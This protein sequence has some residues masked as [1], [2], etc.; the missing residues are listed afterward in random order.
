MVTI[1]PSF[2][3]FL[4]AHSRKFKTRQESLFLIGHWSR[5]FAKK[6]NNKISNHAQKQN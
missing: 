1:P 6:N 4:Y 5:I 2:K 3:S